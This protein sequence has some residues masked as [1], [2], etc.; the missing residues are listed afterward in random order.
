M[1]TETPEEPADPLQRKSR[2]QA[3]HR[4]TGHH[5]LL[6]L[7]MKVDLDGT[8]PFRRTSDVHLPSDG[9]V[10]ILH[11]LRGALYIGRTNSLLRRFGEHEVLPANPLISLARESAVGVLYFSWITL[12]DARRRRAVEA[13]LIRALN[14]PC[15]R[16]IPDLPH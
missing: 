1:V 7:R 11:D 15:N 3:P 9:G 5:P 4:R 2:S 10:Y 13:E 14:P 8:V 12:P 6:D 16:C